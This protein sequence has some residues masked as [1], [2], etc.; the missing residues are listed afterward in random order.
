MR[1]NVEISIIST[2]RNEEDN[3]EE[4]HT[5]L[6]HICER[7][8]KSF[9]IIYV[10]NGSTDKSLE[11]LKG[12]KNA[13]IISLRVPTYIKKSTQTAAID[14]GIKQA[15]G[16]ILVTIDSDLQNPPKE[17]P[18]LLKKLEAD[19][20]DVV[21]G[22]RK[23]RKDNFFIKSLSRFG[24]LLRRKFINPGIHD[25]GCTLKAYRK[26]CFESTVR[27]IATLSNMH[28]EK[29]VE[30]IIPDSRCSRVL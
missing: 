3:L 12:L 16:S 20:L 29:Q 23:D 18:K 10:E 30:V 13:T 25:L 27:C 2:V 17:I 11:I 14:A 6:V 22:W 26:E 21:S 1:N 4:L 19:R 15:K 8:G 28:H 9:E 5:R 7:I 24:S